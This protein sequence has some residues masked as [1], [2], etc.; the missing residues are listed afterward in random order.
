LL[1]RT[2]TSV[3]AP[4]GWHIGATGETKATMGAVTVP[5]NSALITRQG[6]RRLVWWTYSV[7][8]RATASSLDA[9]FLL[10]RAA[11]RPGPHL[12]ALIALSTETDADIPD[13]SILAAFLKV[14]SPP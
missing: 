4:E 13:N 3:I 8:G 5:M 1:T 10:A 7:D 6:K 9:R 14:L 12:G 2:A 11:L